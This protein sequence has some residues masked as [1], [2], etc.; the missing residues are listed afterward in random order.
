MS[1]RT[2][3]RYETIQSLNNG[4]RFINHCDESDLLK[5]ADVLEVNK[6]QLLEGK[7]LKYKDINNDIL[8]YC[9]WVK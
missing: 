4:S 7:E 9:Y 3:I 1:K 6:E 5:I 2:G 8:S